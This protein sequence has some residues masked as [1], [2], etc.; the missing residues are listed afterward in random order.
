MIQSLIYGCTYSCFKVEVI[1]C[2]RK[3][4]LSKATFSPQKC[5]KRK[6]HYGVREVT[7]LIECFENPPSES[8]TE[9]NARLSPAVNC[10][11]LSMFP[12]WI[13]SFPRVPGRP[14]A[15]LLH[16]Q[17]HVSVTCTLHTG[18]GQLHHDSKEFTYGLG[19]T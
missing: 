11:L 14:H 6:K 18:H 4:M 8:V 3:Y 5:S 19:V 1:N 13:Y 12:G 7:A 2:F 17:N 10:V 16:E 15:S 9:K